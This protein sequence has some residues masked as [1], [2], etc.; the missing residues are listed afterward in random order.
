[1]KKL[2]VL[3]LV[4]LI[5][6]TCFAKTNYFDDLWIGGDVTING[7]TITGI[8]DLAVADGGTGSSNASDART[9]LGL[10]IGTNV[11]AWDAQLDD[12]AALIQSDSYIIVG[13]GTNWVQ[14]TGATART[15]LGLAIA[16]DVEA[17]TTA[18]TAIST[19]QAAATNEG[20]L[21]ISSYNIVYTQ[22]DS[23]VTVCTIP[24]NAYVTD[25]KVM[26]TTTFNDSGTLT[27]DI[28][29]SGTLEGYVTDLDIKTADGWAYANV[30]TGFGLSVGGT[31]RDILVSIADQNDDGTAGAATVY[32]EWTMGAPG[33]L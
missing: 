15:S 11:Q 21:F 19:A 29:W 8:T 5:G 12:I 23:A 7:G 33:S 17:H 22:T 26:T 6:V 28:G 31:A 16:A 1:M 24:A 14:E 30:Y 10:A 25:V 27:C 4:L 20:V 32:I 13:D 3:S 2:L 9:A 18:L